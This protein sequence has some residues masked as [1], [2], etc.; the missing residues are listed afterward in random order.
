MLNDLRLI[1]QGV[2][3]FFV[4]KPD[5]PE[6]ESL[7]N[8]F[9][10]FNDMKRTQEETETREKF[11]QKSLPPPFQGKY[12]LGQCSVEEWDSLEQNGCPNHF[13]SLYA[14]DI[15][16]ILGGVFHAVYNDPNSGAGSAT[17]GATQGDFAMT[18]GDFCKGAN[19]RGPKS[20]WPNWSLD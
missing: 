9:I 20:H 1:V 8:S 5:G 7:L 18:R 13:H 3:Y 16:I 10:N 15:Y 11:E 2:K 19:L 14:G 17:Q 12:S 4:C 6:P